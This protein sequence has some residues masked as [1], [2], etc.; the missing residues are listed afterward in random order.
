MLHV[1]E[2]KEYSGSNSAAAHTVRILVVD[3]D[4]ITRE[5]LRAILEKE[6]HSVKLASSGEEALT[7]LEQD[8]FPII[9]SDIHMFGLGGLEL[10]SQLKRSGSQSVVILMTSFGSL[11][12]AIEAIHEGAFDYLSK[13][14]RPEELKELISRALRHW[15]TVVKGREQSA[16]NECEANAQ[17]LPKMLIGRSSQIVQVYKMLA[18]AT[19]ISS[20]VLILGES[21]TGKELVARAIH[22]NSS[23]RSNAFVTIN[24]G[25]L[26]ESLLES[27]LFGHVKGAF[28]G[29]IANKRGLFDEANGGTLFLDE[30]GDVSPALQV[31]L[32]R[33]IQEGEFKPV[34]TNEI[35]KVDC[36]I[37]TATHRDLET[38]VKEGRFR[39]DLYYRL[40]VILI[41]LPPLRERMEDLPELMRHFLRRFTERTK[42]EVVRISDEA[43]EYM[44]NYPWPG[45]IRELEHAIERAVA[46]TNTNSIYPEDLPVEIVNFSESTGDASEEAKVLPVKSLEQMERAHIIRILHEANYNKSKAA[47]IL[48]IDRAT[49]YR[50]AQRYNIRLAEEKQNIHPDAFKKV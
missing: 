29:A 47:D 38:L 10:L 7:I 32:L 15:N 26:T 27:E 24:C 17:M 48:G 21:G 1:S 3:D 4:K 34:G 46:M 43:L 2:L 35:R 23:R 6:N 41:Q 11:Q 13:P 19:L 22:E 45:N 20:N 28:T 37:I 44:K 49:L 33:V 50:K 18:K 25:A 16:P 31:K 39:E 8:S 9:L 14:V 36:R 30:I 40:K 5:L 42:K 12:G